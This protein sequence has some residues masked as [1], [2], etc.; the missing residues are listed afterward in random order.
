LERLEE[1]NSGGGD[2]RDDWSVGGKR[3]GKGM[4]LSNLRVLG[5]AEEGRGGLVVG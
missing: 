1:S 4:G 5:R 2:D 3:N